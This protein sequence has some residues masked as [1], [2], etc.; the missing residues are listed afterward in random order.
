VGKEDA[1]ALRHT[2]LNEPR[3][4]LLATAIRQI[5]EIGGIDKAMFELVKVYE[6]KPLTNEECRAV[7]TSTTGKKISEQ[8]IKPIQILTGGNPRL[9]TIISSF[10]ANMSF[11][12]L[13]AD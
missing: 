12:E 5:D 2:L 9:L 11:K 6:L 1:W 4:M 7:W 3:I 10:G 8:R 13:M